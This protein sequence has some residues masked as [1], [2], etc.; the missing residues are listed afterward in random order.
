MNPVSLSLTILGL[1]SLFWPLATLFFKRHV[2]NA[3]WLMM[4]AMSLMAFS[5]ILLGSLFNTFLIG[6]YILLIMFFIVI[7]ITPPIVHI[8]LTVLT[9]PH[10]SARSFRL[11][12]LPSVFCIAIIILSLIVAGP[13]T[14]RLW[15][16]RGAEG[17]SWVFFPN[18]WR[19]NL[20][21]FVNAYLYW[22]VFAFEF[23]YIFIAGI[24]Q[25]IQFKRI[26][27]EY[28][29][30]DRFHKVNLRG[31]Y[32]A[33]NIGLIIMALSQFINPFG[34]GRRFILY[35]AYCAPLAFI[36]FYIGRSV[37]MI[38]AG[39]E[40]LPSSVQR[41]FSHKDSVAHARLLEN[42]VE[43]ER[44]FLDPDISVF[45]LAQHFHTSEDYII[46]LLHRH[47]GV[48]FGEYVDGL[49]IEYAT[50]QLLEGR[51]LD[52]DDAD[53]LNRFAHS[54]GYLNAADFQHAFSSVMHTSLASWIGMVE[55]KD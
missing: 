51:T 34:E 5:F 41:Q 38:N 4:L 30:S 46:D 17:L 36:S 1:I 21:V 20:V 2:L 9:Q 39:A 22:A 15:T 27:S 10:P 13:D 55:N 26:N 53:S 48:S 11:L 43:H 24:R 45:L 18:S 33:A 44:A 23:I 32:L 25:F 8:A 49:R 12:F 29:T 7:I 31:I 50:A 19:Y 40:Q 28:Y 14:F 3:Q 47:M 54:C 42:Y 52:L 35:F 16:V 37:Y 6:E